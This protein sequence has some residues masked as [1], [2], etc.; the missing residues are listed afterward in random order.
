MDAE[1]TRQLKRESYQR[2][3]GK[4]A[5]S[6]KAT[7]AIRRHTGLCV[8][9]GNPGQLASEVLCSGCLSKRKAY[10]ASVT[11]AVYTA[12]GNVCACC[13][14]KEKSFLTI[15]HVNRDGAEQRMKLAGSRYGTW[16][17]L[18][19]TLRLAQRTGNWPSDLQILCFNCNCGRERNG[20][21]CPHQVRDGCK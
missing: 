3:K 1:R 18:L 7:Y 6:A 9:C 2:H 16:T 10:R 5:V 12:Y 15:D 14:E 20:G 21:V 11:D 4:Y 19:R 8:D 17:F 13:G